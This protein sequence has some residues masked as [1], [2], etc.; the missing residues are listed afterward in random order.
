MEQITQEPPERTLQCRLCLHNADLIVPIFG[1]RG[2]EAQMDK[3]LEMHLNLIVKENENL[4][5]HMCLKCWHTVEYIDSFVQQVATNQSILAYDQQKHIEYIVNDQ[6]LRGNN[7][8]NFEFIEVAIEARANPPSYDEAQKTKQGTMELVEGEIEITEAS[9]DEELDADNA[10]HSQTEFSSDEAER[11]ADE[12]IIPVEE[13]GILVRVNGYPFPE[14]IRDG[15][16]IVRGEELDKCL[17]AYYGLVC[18]LCKEENWSTMEDLFAHYQKTH[19]REGF[20][21]CCGKQIQKR[22]MIAMHL[23]KH[24]QPEAFECPICKKMMTTPRILRFH[25]QNHLPEEKRPLRCELC[26]RRFSYVS[27]LLVHA[28]T[29]RKEN[30]TKRVY[31]LCQVCGRAFRSAENLAGHMASSH[32]SDGGSNC[33][34]CDVCHKKFSSR[35]NLNYHL[36]THEPKVL[37]QVQCENCGKWL[38]NKICL[39]KHMLQHSLVRH[40]CDQCDYAATNVQSLQNHKRVQ[41]TDEKPFVCTTCGKSFKLKSNLRVHLAQHRDGQKYACEFCSRRFTSRS[42]YYGHRKR[43]HLEEYERE[44]LRKEQEDRANRIKLKQN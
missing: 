16:L 21:N 39:R 19:G 42:N 28:S 7:R 32:E 23:A 27:A 2:R 34:E 37:H 1:D 22:Q 8:D 33:V 24:V 12:S 41:H 29:H 38:K 40:G 10:I 20:V 26:P 36:T 11:I 3:M 6:V 17:T 18:E 15:K 4:P 35:S 9:V 25:V 13:A 14:M 30:E 44:K 5:K 31:H 43:M